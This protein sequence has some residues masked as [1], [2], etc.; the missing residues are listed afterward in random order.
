[1]DENNNP[2]DAKF[3]FFVEDVSDLPVIEYDIVAPNEFNLEQTAD[4]RRIILAHEGEDGPLLRLTAN[5]IY[6][7]ILEH[8]G[9]FGW[10]G[11]SSTIGGNSFELVVV[12]RKTVDLKWK[13]MD[14]LPDYGDPPGRRGL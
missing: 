3:E 4:G 6:D 5:D 11:L 7:P 2:F 13:Q 1:M 9:T 8:A 12:D 10:G 14:K